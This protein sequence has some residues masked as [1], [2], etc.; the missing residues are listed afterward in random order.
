MDTVVAWAARAAALLGLF[1]VSSI[2]C[3]SPAAH[4]QT[5]QRDTIMTTSPTSTASAEPAAVWPA[6]TYY[7]S[8]DVQG[9]RIFYREAGERGHPVVL[10]LH[11]YP[12]SSHSYRELI[13]LLSGRYHVL[14]PDYLGSGFSDRPS[15]NEI[16]YTFDLLAEYVAGF[17]AALGLERY[18]MYMQDFGSPVGYRVALRYPERLRGLVV[19]NANAYVEGL[20]ENRLGLFRRAHDD[21]SAE[22]L[23]LL[24]QVVSEQGVRDRQYLRDV[25]GE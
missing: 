5:A 9:R 22:G 17:V 6:K 20:S 15:P 8:V 25:P 21:R 3:A 4:A 11:G 24:E 12:A 13:P 2:G 1:G 23:A 10:L 16:T 7:R 18:V 14:A 19:Q